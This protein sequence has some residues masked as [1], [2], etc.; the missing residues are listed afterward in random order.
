MERFQAFLDMGGY[1]MFVWPAYAIA[2]GVLIGLLVVSLR[3]MRGHE[4]ALRSLR[5]H[6]PHR[7]RVSGGSGND[8]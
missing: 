6:L 1:A 3:G 8:A 5:S 2:I 4:E 7:A